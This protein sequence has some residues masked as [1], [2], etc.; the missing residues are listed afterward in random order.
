MHRKSTN[1]SSKQTGTARVAMTVRLP[2]NVV[3]QIDEQLDQ[4]DIPLS[5]NNWMLEA[6]IEKLRKSSPGGSNGS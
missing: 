6:A 3:Q 2:E 1:G 5:R 4:R